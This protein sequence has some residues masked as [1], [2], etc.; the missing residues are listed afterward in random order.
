MTQTLLEQLA[1]ELA[2]KTKKAG[3]KSPAKY[4]LDV[5]GSL[6]AQR[7]TNKKELK[8]AIVAI[9]IAKPTSK[10][11]VYKLE[12]PVDVN[13]PVSGISVDEVEGE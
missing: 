5:N 7:P 9:K 11:N 12:G 6:V 4:V 13:L 8:A 1:A 2:V 3:K 10:I